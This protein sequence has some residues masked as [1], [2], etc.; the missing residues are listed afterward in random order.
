MNVDGV[1]IATVISS[2]VSAVF[3]C[4]AL[5]GRMGLWAVRMQD[6][7][8]DGRILFRIMRIGIPTGIQ[9]AVFAVAND[10]SGSHQQPQDDCH[11]GVQRRI[12]YRGA[13]LLYPEFLQPGLYDFCR[14][15]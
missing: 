6:L 7:R 15:E 5:P 1:A 10:Y 3:F 14:A 13:R 12:Q 8:P 4:R 9:M 2:A 11:G